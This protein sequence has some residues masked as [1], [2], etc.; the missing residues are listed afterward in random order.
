MHLI[1]FDGMRKRYISRIIYSKYF[2][3]FDIY[4]YI[5]IYIYIIEVNTL[6]IYT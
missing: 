4:I 3:L 1:C 2:D 6:D 5:Y